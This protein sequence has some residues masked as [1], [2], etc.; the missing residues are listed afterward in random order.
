MNGPIDCAR[1]AGRRAPLFV[2][3]FLPGVCLML[4]AA[5]SSPAAASPVQDTQN[6]HYYEAI[7]RSQGIAWAA[8]NQEA[9]A[10]MFNGMHGHLATIT[11]PDENDFLTKALPDAVVGGYWL[12]GF[13]SHGLLDPAAGWQW[14]TGEPW[15]YTNWNNLTGS[16]PNDYEGPGTSDQDENRLHFWYDAEGAWNDSGPAGK[17]AGYVVEY[18][19]DPAGAPPTITGYAVDG[20]AITMPNSVP[21]G[22]LLRVSGTNLGTEGTV[23]FD[24]DLLPAAVASWNP[25]QIRVWVPAAPSY[26]FNTHVTVITNRRQAAGGDFTITPPAPGH[27]NLLANG[28]FDFPDSS[29]SDLDSGYTYGQPASDP[30]FNGYGIPGWRIPFGTIDVYQDGWQQAPGRAKQSIDLVGSSPGLIAQT[31]YTEPGR[32]YDFSG[33][34]SHNPM[35]LEARADVFLNDQFFV[36]LFHKRYNSASNMEWSPFLFRFRATDAQ[37]TLWIEDVTGRTHL[38]GTALAGLSV[39]P[40]PP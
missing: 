17:L 40:A 5:L 10:R 26:P 37:T 20:P 4:A 24:G 33:W 32:Q 19:P 39:T 9:N 36:Q 1:T 27:D 8:A 12:G 16:E 6:G 30:G 11:T 38:A 3:R 15:S 7:A 34:V 2:G 18:E 29:S 35:L 23:L 21:P 25:A 31:F 13:Q 28:S 14:I 22:T